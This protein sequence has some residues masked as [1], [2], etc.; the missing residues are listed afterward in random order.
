MLSHYL[1]GINGGCNLQLESKIRAVFFEIL[2][3]LANRLASTVDHEEAFT[4]VY[5]F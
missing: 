3:T 5:S 2:E 1:D 4:L